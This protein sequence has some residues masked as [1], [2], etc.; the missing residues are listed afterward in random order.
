MNNSSARRLPS[1]VLIVSLAIVAFMA[2]SV[3]VGR[4]LVG[5]RAGERLV[6]VLRR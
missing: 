5:S 6:A 3:L 1:S 2:S 4:G